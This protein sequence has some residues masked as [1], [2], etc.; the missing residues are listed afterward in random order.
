MP[1]L[2]FIYKKPN[3]GYLTIEFVYGIR[4]GWMQKPQQKYILRNK[5][6]WIKKKKKIKN[7]IMTNI[8]I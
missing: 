5:K 8:K 6:Y 1:R 4:L 3:E 7:T 2:G